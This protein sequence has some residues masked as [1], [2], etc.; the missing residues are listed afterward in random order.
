MSNQNSGSNLQIRP[1]DLM[2]EL[3]I[4]KD[5]Y[6][7]DLS[8]LGIKAAKD[9]DGRAYLTNEQADLVRQLRSHV[10]ETGRRDGFEPTRNSQLVHNQNTSN[11][12]SVNTSDL[13]SV[14]EEFE[15]I[16]AEIDIPEF[17]YRSS[18]EI[19]NDAVSQ[20]INEAA[21]LK[22]QNTVAPDLIKLHL[23]DQMEEEDLPVQMQNQIEAVR[24]AAHP[25]IQPAS[26]A[27]NLLTEFR[28]NRG[29]NS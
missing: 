19:D 13:S 17:E 3:G 23:A 26:V 28:N 10:N 1:D 15:E 29:G 16:E 18:D 21:H 11:L 12:S 8:Y 25:K 7:A 4:K 5:S 24:E 14:K 2:D 22:M 6:Y 9:D 27:N 20:L